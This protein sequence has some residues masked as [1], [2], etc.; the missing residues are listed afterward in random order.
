[1]VDRERGNPKV[2]GSI[3]AWDVRDVFFCFFEGFFAVFKFYG[4]G[5]SKI[6]S[7]VRKFE[8]MFENSKLCSKIRKF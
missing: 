3:P 1:M 6:R 8:V 4:P 2:A 7:Y 5:I